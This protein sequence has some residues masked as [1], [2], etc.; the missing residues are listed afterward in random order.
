MTEHEAMA[1]PAAIRA[2][3]ERGIVSVCRG[4]T[5][6]VAVLPRQDGTM[7]TFYLD[8]TPHPFEGAC[9]SA[10]ILSFLSPYGG[11]SG[12]ELLAEHDRDMLNDGHHRHHHDVHGHA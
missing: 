10:E 9:D 2:W 6:K 7:G 8:G 1:D 4:C 11:Y 5:G 3:E 12:E